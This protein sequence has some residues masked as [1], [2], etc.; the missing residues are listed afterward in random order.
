MQFG[1]EVKDLFKNFSGEKALDGVSFN[2]PQGCLFGLIGADGAGK[3]TLMRILTT[4]IDADKGSARVMG[5]DVQKDYKSIRTMIGYMPQK[6]SL[7]PDLSVA[8]NLMFFADIFDVPRA[9]RDSRMQ[10]LL[11]FARLEPF[12][13][14]RAANLSGG[15]K[16]KL[17]LCCC[18]VHTPQALFLDEP[19][20]GVDPVSRK[21]FWEILRDLRSRGIAILFSTPYMDEAGKC[22]DLLLLD[23]GRV[24][25]GG[26][27]AA[28]VSSFPYLLFRVESPAGSLAWPRHTALPQGVASIYP[29]SG[30]LHATCSDTTMD[31]N[32]LLSQLRPSVPAAITAK[33][34]EAGIEDAFIYHLSNTVKEA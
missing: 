4:L 8:E 2:V 29:S 9:E 16:Q 31:E 3:S 20:T 19:T 12:R 32:R 34:I 26:T 15:M 18:L 17:A 1:I 6:F 21:E 7:Y 28:L 11:S 22:D 27:P 24:I 30:A 13:E 5:R 14:R 25:A 33:R 10:R 23:H